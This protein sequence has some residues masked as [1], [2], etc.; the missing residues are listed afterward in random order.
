MH[1]N[2]PWCLELVSWI[3][4]AW[5][6]AQGLYH[7]LCDHRTHTLTSTGFMIDMEMLPRAIGNLQVFQLCPSSHVSK[8]DP[9]ILLWHLQESN[10][11]LDRYLLLFKYKS[12]KYNLILPMKHAGEMTDS[13]ELVSRYTVKTYYNIRTPN[14][15][16]KWWWILLIEF[17]KHVR[18]PWQCRLYILIT[19]EG[20]TE[21]QAGGESDEI[22]Q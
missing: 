1:D 10:C 2:T 13:L 19:S 21:S 12:V 6:A 4:T 8:C 7:T 15:R 18:V 16:D 5:C 20:F 22:S 9:T 11:G 14:H 3:S 17:S